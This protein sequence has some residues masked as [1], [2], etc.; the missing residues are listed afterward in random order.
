MASHRGK[1]YERGFTLIELMIA[2]IVL[3]L[4]AGFAT[5]SLARSDSAQSYNEISR[6]PVFM[7]EAQR[8]AVLKQSPQKLEFFDEKIELSS[9][10]E[11]GWSFQA[12]LIYNLVTETHFAV[13]DIGV[14][15]TPENQLLFLPDG[16]HALFD[17]AI[18]T[19]DDS[20]NIDVTEIGLFEL[21]HLDSENE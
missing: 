16:G 5:L 8:W 12:E 13:K 3:G 11:D 1:S 9:F 4:L 10:T 20:Y 18:N 21:A 17:F 14:S 2:T 19:E 15:N 6:I 7:K